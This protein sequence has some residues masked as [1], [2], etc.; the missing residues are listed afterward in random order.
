MTMFQHRHYEAIAKIFKDTQAIGDDE[1]LK[2][3]IYEFMGMFNQDNE[4][5]SLSRFYKA[6][7][8]SK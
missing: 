2:T 5:F 8:L 1:Q 4:R 7:G 3:L 6:C